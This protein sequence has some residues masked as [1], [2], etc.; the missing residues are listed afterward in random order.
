MSNEQSSASVLLIIAHPDDEILCGAGT[1]ALCAERGRPVT[2]VCAT[3]GEL[4]PIADPQLATRENLGAVR[5]LE[6]RASCEALGIHE[7]HWLGLPDAGVDWAAPMQETVR[8]LVSLIRRQRPRVLISFGPDG[9]YGHSDHVAV[10]ELTIEAR[11]LAA[12]PSFAAE[13]GADAYWAPR[14]FYPVLTADT[15]SA[16]LGELALAGT[17]AQLWSLPPSAFRV[18]PSEITGSVDVTS[19][20]PRKLRALHSHRTQ[21]ES[22]NALGLLSGALAQRFLGVEHFRCADGLSGDPVSG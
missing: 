6:L 5:E 22:D 21:L 20:L 16:M 9:L 7:L 10:S 14:L 18:L 12:D 2:L 17:R 3:R 11:R 19:V 8:A 1:L 4:G 15:V 13:G